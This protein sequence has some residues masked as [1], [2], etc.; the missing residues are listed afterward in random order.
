VHIGELTIQCAVLPDGR[1]VL[2]QRG[3]G[4]ALGRGYGGSDW[5]NQ[6]QDGGGNLPFF[7]AAKSLTPFISNELLAL[8][9]EP[10]KYLHGK[11]G[12]VAH[13]VNAT[14]LP[15][16]CDVWLK[17]REAG[18]LTEPQRAVAQKAEI[19]MRGLAHIGILALVDEATGYQEVRDKNALQAILEKYVRKELAAWAKRFPDDFYRELYR[20]RGWEWRGMTGNRI[21]ACAF[22][23]KDLIYDRIAPGLLT[24]LEAKNPV[25]PS[26][27]RKGAHHQL[28]TEDIGIPKLAEHFGS[29]VT[30]Q[31]ISQ[32]WPSFMMLMDRW[33]P[34]RGDTLMLD[35]DEGAS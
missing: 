26:G 22:Y 28:L 13:G 17:A 33:H 23:T 30:L 27:R 32:D 6:E 31:R 35:F 8:V 4:R 20:L 18:I 15:Q 2:S 16:I 10:I 21:S 11:G 3:V 7:M 34:R 29:V 5:K 24:E 19:L 25:L 9:T 12:G 1:R 14:A